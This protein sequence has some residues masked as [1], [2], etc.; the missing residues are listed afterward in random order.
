MTKQEVLDNLLDAF[1]S[2]SN[3][4]IAVNCA[5]LILGFSPQSHTISELAEFLAEEYFYSKPGEDAFECV[6]LMLQCK[7][8]DLKTIVCRY[9]EHERMSQ[10]REKLSSSTSDEI[11]DQLM[12]A[13][14][15]SISFL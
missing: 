15:V 3:T 14:T 11:A 1:A 2:D 13:I 4:S 7:F 6:G 8:I 9:V 5:I 12:K 10:I